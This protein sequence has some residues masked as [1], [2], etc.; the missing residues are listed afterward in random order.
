M[1]IAKN[2]FVRSWKR[3]G[4][5][6]FMEIICL[7]SGCLPFLVSNRN[8]SQLIRSFRF[9]L[10]NRRASTS[11]SDSSSAAVG[12][13]TPPPPEVAKSS[14][15]IAN[16]V[17]DSGTEEEIPL[18]NVPTTGR[19]AGSFSMKSRCHFWWSREPPCDSMGQGQAIRLH[20]I[21]SRVEFQSTREFFP[22]PADLWPNK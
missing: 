2:K 22:A 13:C 16:M 17:D 12:F 4:C 9:G 21:Q 1:W 3:G 11:G 14:T 8:W 18:P 20:P 19:G 7:V 5:D 10:D 15:L 6:P